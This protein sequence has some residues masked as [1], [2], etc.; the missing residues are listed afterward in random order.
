MDSGVRT[1]IRAVVSKCDSGMAE[2]G[3]LGWSLQDR[4]H[5]SKLKIRLRNFGSPVASPIFSTR[6]SG[7]GSGAV[8]FGDG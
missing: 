1:A 8:F 5:G 7:R 6:K 3:L 2:L 4:K